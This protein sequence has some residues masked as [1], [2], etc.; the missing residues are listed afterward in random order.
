MRSEPK[1][2]RDTSPPDGAWQATAQQGACSPKMPADTQVCRRQRR[3]HSVM[4]TEDPLR[5]PRLPTPPL[6]RDMT[7]CQPLACTS[8]TTI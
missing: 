7:V 2:R 5:P 3:E 4:L 6:S 8:V 1:E